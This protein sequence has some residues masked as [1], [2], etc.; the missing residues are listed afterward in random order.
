[1]SVVAVVGYAKSTSHMPYQT[2]EVSSCFSC[3]TPSR[4]V[5]IPFPPL[6]HRGEGRGDG[7]GLLCHP[8]PGTM[9]L[10]VHVCGGVV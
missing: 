2:G 3:F 7:L 10:G 4:K 5:I 9:P 8:I 1:M 6:V